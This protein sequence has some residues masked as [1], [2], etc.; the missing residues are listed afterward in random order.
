ME[1]YEEILNYWFEDLDEDSIISQDHP[2]VRKWFDMSLET[3]QY[4]QDQFMSDYKEAI[5]GTYDHWIH[6]PRGRLALIIIYDQFSRNLFRDSAKAFEADYKA[7]ELALSSLKDG[8]DGRVNFIE[9]I[10]YYMPLMHAENIEIQTISVET[11][12][13]FLNEAERYEDQNVA[14]FQVTL[15]YAK[16]HYDVIKQ[17]KRFPHRNKALDRRS[18]SDETAFIHANQSFQ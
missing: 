3:D 5:A 8:F 4:I 13:K 6:D 16:Q 17:F 14:Y 18:T 12:E 9:R 7:L 1:R 2:V 11:F 10:F 15:A